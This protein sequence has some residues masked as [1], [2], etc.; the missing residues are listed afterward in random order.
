MFDGIYTSY[1][2]Y[3]T[4]SNLF[5]AFHCPRLVLVKAEV[6]C[7]RIF[8]FVSLEL[9][10]LKWENRILLKLPHVI[11]SSFFS[12]T[13]SSASP[14]NSGPGS[15]RKFKSSSDMIYSVVLEDEPRLW[16][17]IFLTSLDLHREQMIRSSCTLSFSA[18]FPSARYFF[19]SRSWGNHS[20]WNCCLEGSILGLRR[21]WTSADSWLN[22]TAH[23]WPT[24]LLDCLG[25]EKIIL[26]AGRYPLLCFREIPKSIKR[27]SCSSISISAST[28]HLPPSSNIL[29]TNPTTKQPQ[30]CNY[31]LS[32]QSLPSRL[33]VSWH[34]HQVSIKTV[35]FLLSSAISKFKSRAI[36]TTTEAHQAS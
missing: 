27:S 11:S 21:S 30:T 28:H 36:P 6:S 33:L 25:A 13:S 4:T 9:L 3:L 15:W 35:W 22:I 17:S 19:V 7:T 24:G 20:L 10:P 12:I 2:L 14:G 31:H 1:L 32:S 8:T 18:I 34:L 5:L 23:G 16:N 26:A 29:K